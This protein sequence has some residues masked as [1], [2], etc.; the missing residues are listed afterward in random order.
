MAQILISTEE[1]FM[2]LQTVY[3][4]RKTPQ[5]MIEEITKN[6]TM[7]KVNIEKLIKQLNKIFEPTEYLIT[8]NTISFYA[9]GSQDVLNID[10]SKVEKKMEKFKKK[11]EKP[12]RK[13]ALWL[14]K[15][16]DEFPFRK[17]TE[18]ENDYDYEEDDDDYEEDYYDDYDE[19][20]EDYEEELE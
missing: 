14:E 1:L 20:D 7:E 13:L 19:E 11:E 8:N 18:T 4:G 12:Y 17:E 2:K 5:E 16:Y 6:N 10:M 9:R 15:K 3:E